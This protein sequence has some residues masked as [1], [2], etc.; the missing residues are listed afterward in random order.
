M[1]SS[2][3]STKGHPKHEGAIGEGVITLWI[4]S[5]SDIFSDFDPRPFSERAISDDFIAQVK[6][7]SRESS[8]K[9]E[10]LKL[11]VPEGTQKEEH[12]KVIKKR[13]QSYFYNICTQLR[14]EIR[15]IRNRGLVF[16]FLGVGLMIAA[17]YIVFLNLPNFSYK[18]LLTLCEPG[19]WFL[20]W[21]G[22]DLIISIYGNKQ[23]EFQFYARM[24]NTH[25]EFSCYK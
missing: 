22:L 23:T 14:I 1:T 18:L 6:R 17:S 4:D 25:V 24:E 2:K 13:L 11:L 15:K 10:M 19:G 3:V 9:I 7:V 20:F 16:A 8:N 12:E 5:Y 21:T